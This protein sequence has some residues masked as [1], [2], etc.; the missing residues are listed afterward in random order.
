MKCLEKRI[1]P[2]LLAAICALGIFATA[3]LAPTVV[4]SS[5]VKYSAVGLI[6]I[7]GIVF[8]ATGVLSFRRAKTTVNPLNPEAAT[9]LVTS[10]IYQITRIPMY[11]GFGLLLS[12]WAVYWGAFW[13]LGLIALFIVYLQRFQ[14]LPEEK[15]L[16]ALF[17]REF[18]N[19]KNQVRRWL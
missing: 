4:L 3:Q 8:M 19:Y 2:P 7:F 18:S 13:G 14:I 5:V 16:E 12:A 15:A 9:S 10:G 6:S 1:P 17:G 11:V